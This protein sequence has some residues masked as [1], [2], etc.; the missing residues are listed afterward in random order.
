MK[1]VLR[2]LIL[3]FSFLSAV[4]VGYAQLKGSLK[5]RILNAGTR[6]PV[7]F[8]ITSVVKA[9][10]SS[11]ITNANTGQDGRVTIANLN[12]G[13]YKLV[14]KQLGMTAKVVPF[15]IT[16]ANPIVDLGTINMDAEVKSLN[17]V[18]VEGQQAAV[19][20]KKD[21][22]EFNAGSFKTQPNDNVEQLLKKLPGVEVDKDGK[23]TAQ[24]QQI[25]KV[26]VDGKEFFGNDPKAATK[27]LPADAIAKVQL[28]DD[29]TEKTK[30]TGID[31][32]QREK[33]LNLTLKEDKKKGW[34]GN[35]TATGGNSDRFLGQFNINRFD[36][37]KQFSALFL[38]NNV[39]ESGFSME[40][41]NAFT[42][43]NTFD[44]FRSADGNTTINIGSSGRANV[45]GIFSGVNGGLIT[46]HTGG[47][48]YSDLWGSKDQVKFN[49]SLVS[50]VS[51]NNLVQTDALENP[52]QNLLTNQRSVGKNQ[53]NS[54][55]LYMTLE[56]KMDSLTTM[57][58]RPN[59][60]YG[61]RN[62]LNSVIYNTTNYTSTP[63]NQGSQNLDQTT[64]TPV[65]AGELSINRR[66]SNGRGSYNVFITGSV[67]P[68][69]NT[70]TNNSLITRYDSG[71]LRQ[72]S[73]SNL[74]TDQSAGSNAINGV[75]SHV[76][77]I[78]KAR[79]LNFTLSQ[80][81]QYRHDNTDQN[82]LYYNPVTGNYD[83]YAAQ[84]SGLYNNNN[85]NYSSS[86]G[87]NKAGD[88]LTVN[89]NA[90]VSNLGLNGNV[91]TMMSS[92]ER[93]EWAFLPNASISY[94]PKTGTSFSVYVRADATLP[95]LT[96]LQPFLNT[97]NTTYKRLGN[98]DLSM[99]RSA[100]ANINFNTYD[101]KS[102]NYLNFYGNFNYYWNGFS[103]E[104]FT[105]Q[106]GVITSRPINADGNYNLYL[107][108]NLG[109]PTKIK[110]LRLNLGFN[111]SM[112]RT[113]NFI[114]NNKNAVLRLS[115]GV[116][117]GGSIDRDVYQL[118][119][120][121]YTSYNNAR[122][123]Y[124]HAADRQYFNINNYY[125]ASVKPFKNWRIYGDLSQTLYRGKPVSNNTS[126]Y[127][128]SAGI[129]HYLLKGQ[130]LTL[131]LNGFDLLN[132]NAA[133]Q[134]SLSATGVTTRTET[135]TIGQYFSLRLTYK[136]SR[137][138]TQ[139]ASS[140]GG[141]IILK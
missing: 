135:N 16:S 6:E 141:I 26:Y 121:T 72:D 30:N 19:K 33:V 109:K 14:V 114:D 118:S 124:Q 50:V 57:R 131:G 128:L 49:A 89:L 10:D 54:Y 18:K 123:S 122:N 76:R 90:K 75:V 116:S 137:V 48:N 4:N 73:T 15:N 55:R 105:D 62:G 71:G 56:Y 132:Q 125:S 95:A 25:S 101:P 41:L 7:E 47:L 91:N 103:T 61:Y 67:S 130:N 102:N 38:S 1:I 69:S 112:N 60:S 23:V 84:Y 20:V 92:I 80:S 110:G 9:A 40:D 77:Q 12:T 94:R 86:V 108:G 44:A 11:T 5:A 66:L 127:L 93:N 51:F 2:C 117:L 111:G 104:S 3:S 136:L 27:N 59:I 24:G 58:L 63:Q 46:N 78:N 82:T 31:D 52:A 133:L 13:S 29:K 113:I 32:G 68:Y 119:L 35:A 43:G 100:V 140:N 83:L 22:V 42:G 88:K 107:G 99:S 65:I 97:A 115:P 64:R 74:Y 79:K 120:R 138:G 39:N 36:K 21:T 106:G 87:L 85:Y 96:D 34:F 126:V 45:N 28:I 129:E 37:Q 98:P 70:Y 8:A 134:R 81:I 53:Y 139:N 17:A